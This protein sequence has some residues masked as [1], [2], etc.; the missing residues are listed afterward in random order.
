MLQNLVTLASSVKSTLHYLLYGGYKA[1]Q[2][3]VNCGN[4]L[5]RG[6]CEGATTLHT[7]FLTLYDSATIFLQDNWQFM[8]QS[9]HFIVSTL[10]TTFNSLISIVCNI[11]TFLQTSLNLFLLICNDLIAALSFIANSIYKTIFVIRKMIIVFGSAIWF[12]ITFIPMT[13]YHSC[14][15][16]STLVGNLYQQAPQIFLMG[17]KGITTFIKNIIDFVWDIPIKSLAGLTIATILIYTFS[18]FSVAITSYCGEKLLLIRSLFR[19]RKSQAEDQKPDESLATDKDCVI[20]QERVKCI[21]LLPC[22]HVC[23]CEECS[24]KMKDYKDEC[25]ICRSYI[26]DAMKIYL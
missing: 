13:I 3:L 2:F 18:K 8:Q 23:L 22:K 15:F 14:I 1:G 4:L 10:E 25:P 21:L 9:V 7:F 6:S 19:R 26:M 5:V 12:L 24:E 16:F 17:S 11:A 20:C